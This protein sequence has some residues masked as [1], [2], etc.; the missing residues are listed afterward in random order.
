MTIGANAGSDGT[1]AVYGVAIGGGA[2]QTA[3][4]YAATA[5]GGQAGQLNQQTGAVAIGYAA[6]CQY[7]QAGAIAIGSNAGVGDASGTSNASIQHQFAIAIGA[8]AGSNAQEDYA[9]AIGAYAGQTSQASNSIILNATG[10]AVNPATTGFFVAPLRSTNTTTIAL[11]YNTGTN[12]I[13]ATAAPPIALSSITGTTTT[14]DQVSYGYYY[15]ISNS[16]FNGITLPSSIP[17]DTGQF[18]VFR[19]TTVSYLSVT[20]TNY[21]S[22]TSPI[23]IAPQTSVTIVVSGTGGSSDG[24]ILF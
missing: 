17:T 21:G 14:V 5:V 10:V 18:W 8:N 15:Y 1:V 9:I 4:G 23:S 20:M 16:G 2:G 22:M 7:Q 6:G 13:A 12:E 19:N 3:Q 24:Y 11:G